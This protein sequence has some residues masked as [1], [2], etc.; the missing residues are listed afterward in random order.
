M[1]VLSSSREAGV[2]TLAPPK[3][4]EPFIRNFYQIDVGS[5]G[6]TPA[7]GGP[8]LTVDLWWVDGAPAIVKQPGRPDKIYRGRLIQ[9]PM[10][11][12]AFFH[13]IGRASGFGVSLKP[14]G[15]A[16]LGIELA[17]LVDGEADLDYALKARVPGL[18]A[19][20]QNALSVSKKISA[21]ERSLLGLAGCDPMEERFRRLLE[22]LGCSFADASVANIAAKIGCTRQTLHNLSVRFLGI[23]PKTLI[24]VLRLRAALALMKK[25]AILNSTDIASECGYADQSHFIRH[26]LGMTG[27]TPSEPFARRAFPP[28]LPS[29]A[30]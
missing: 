17:S 12:M 6:Y 14:R 3:A 29:E 21:I 4:L 22:G 10:T 18:S 16:L 26:C 27:M 20:V 25:Q 23:P 24:R 11:R 7:I 9:G 28:R 30:G 1:P 5:S 8:T 19:E 15:A 2:V 13:K